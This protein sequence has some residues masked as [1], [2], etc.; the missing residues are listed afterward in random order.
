M[1]VTESS[2]TGLQIAAC[3]GQHRG[4]RS[5]QQDRVAVLQGRQAQRCA[6]G[7]LA[8]GLG[9]RSGGALAADGAARKL[10]ESL[11]KRDGSG[12]PIDGAAAY[13]GQAP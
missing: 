5:E 4:D 10:P 7:V 2:L 6:L 8:D 11:G 13:I 1:R 12:T 3:T 9:G